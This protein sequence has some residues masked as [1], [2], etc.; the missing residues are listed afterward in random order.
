M[1]TKVLKNVHI[2]ELI[3]VHSWCFDLITHIHEEHLLQ[4]GILSC[5][6]LYVKDHDDNLQK[7]KR[8]RNCERLREFEEMK[9]S[10]QSCKITRRKT[11]K[12]FFWIS[13]K[14]S[15]SGSIDSDISTARA[16]IG[17]CKKS[18]AIYDFYCNSSL[19]CKIKWDKKCLS[20]CRKQQKFC[21]NYLTTA[22]CAP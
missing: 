18:N 19:F 12:T 13:S 2:T 20:F 5:A 17:V 16:V 9:I 8:Q 15:A 10:R 14:N 11:L 7:E 21:G 4:T 3:Y 1:N 6:Y 22:T